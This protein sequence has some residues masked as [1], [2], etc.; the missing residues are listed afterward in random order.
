MFGDVILKIGEVFSKFFCIHNYEKSSVQ[1][2]TQRFLVKECESCGR[3]K[4]KEI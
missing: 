4:V 1:I 3:I 2:G